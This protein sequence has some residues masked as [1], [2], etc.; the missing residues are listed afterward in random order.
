MCLTPPLLCWWAFKLLSLWASVSGAALTVH[1]SPCAWL[2]LCCTL[3]VAQYI[4]G[5]FYVWFLKNWQCFWTILKS[6]QQYIGVLFL[7]FSP[8]LVLLD[9]FR[10]PSLQFVEWCLIMGLF[11]FVFCWGFCCAWLWVCVFITVH[12]CV[13]V[14]K[15]N[16]DIRSLPHALSTFS[17][18][19]SHNQIQSSLIWQV[20][21]V[22]LLWDPISSPHGLELQVGPSNIYGMLEIWTQV[23]VASI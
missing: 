15:T 21:L 16:T 1:F 8:K 5:A 4:E 2:V 23:L 22:S 18:E 13:S 14:Q 12:T 11:C 19:M 20:Q 3:W 9:F 17:I 6:H 10:W 7:H